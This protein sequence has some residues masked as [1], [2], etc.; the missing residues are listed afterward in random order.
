MGTG[1]AQETGG[2]PGEL[3]GDAGAL[4]SFDYESENKPATTEVVKTETAAAGDLELGS[5]VADGTGEHPGKPPERHR[6]IGVGRV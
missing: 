3:P 4:E 2:P 5:G 1:V 6:V